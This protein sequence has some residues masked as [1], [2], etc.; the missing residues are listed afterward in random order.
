MDIMPIF[1]LG[2]LCSFLTY[3]LDNYLLQEFQL[4]DFL[5]LIIDTVF[6]YTAFL[7]ISYL[8]KLNPIHDIKQLILQI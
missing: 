1:L 2:L 5:R 3:A 7:G 4:T 6:F 8:I